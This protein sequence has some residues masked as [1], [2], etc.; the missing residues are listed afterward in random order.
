MTI[1]GSL[2]RPNYHAVQAPPF[3]NAACAFDG[4]NEPVRLTNM[5]ENPSVPEDPAA[6]GEED[7]G[8]GDNT[9]GKRIEFQKK[10]RASE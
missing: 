8:I 10:Q 9:L 2:E 4:D 1:D 3:A 7:S 6:S 5:L